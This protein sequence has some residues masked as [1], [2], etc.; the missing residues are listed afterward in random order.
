MRKVFFALIFNFFFI[1]SSYGIENLQKYQEDCLKYIDRPIVEL[2]SSYGKLR[3]NFD[4]DEAYL[5][6]ETE[7]KFEAQN[8]DFSGDFSPIG[9]T[10]VR[11]S[12]D[13]DFTA[14][15]IK[16]NHG[17]LCV[18]PSKIRMRLEYLMPTIYILKDLKEGSCLYDLALRHEKTHM[19]IYI[20]A[21]DYFLPILK[22]YAES[23][24][25]KVGVMV[26]SAYEPEGMAAQMLHETYLKKIQKKVNDWQTEVEQEQL[27]LDSP[28]NYILE[29]SLCLEVEKDRAELGQ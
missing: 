19:Q 12:F 10:K 16:L 18:Y 8:E 26:I 11:D 17:Y 15:T 25:D 5:K 29:N 21:L 13:F 7:L 14:E 20:E 27:K 23:L 1:Y 4:K 9:L 24:F 2:V 3:Y 22:E 28:Q 6:R